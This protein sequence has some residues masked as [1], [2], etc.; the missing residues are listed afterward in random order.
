VGP[1]SGSSDE[2]EWDHKNAGKADVLEYHFSQL[3]SSFICDGR[4]ANSFILHY[5]LTIHLLF[6][7]PLIHLYEIMADHMQDIRDLLLTFIA[8]PD[9]LSA[10]LDQ[11][12]IEVGEKATQLKRLQNKMEVAINMFP[13]SPRLLLTSLIMQLMDHQSTYSMPI[14]SVII[15]VH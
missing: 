7:Y 10:K 6:T 14:S 4:Q 11:L 3:Q 13:N 2:A 8:K 15:V 1:K 5:D 12:S 9:R